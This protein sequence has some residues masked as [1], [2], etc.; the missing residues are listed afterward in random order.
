MGKI[1]TKPRKVKTADART[2]KLLRDV[3]DGRQ[4]GEIV[5]R[6][7][8]THSGSIEDVR[9]IAEGE[10]LFDE[11]AGSAVTFL[12]NEYDDFYSGEWA[13]NTLGEMEVDDK[14]TPA[15]F[16]FTEGFVHAVRDVW[17]KV[18]SKQ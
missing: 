1:K 18:T 16:G 4:R 11:F 9:S 10:Q 7:W 12:A 3:N 2:N 6:E 15:E 8:G 13:Q 17:K 14:P 5:G